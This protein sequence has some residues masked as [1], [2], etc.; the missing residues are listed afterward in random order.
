M[1]AHQHSDSVIDMA[2]IQSICGNDTDRI[3][4]YFSY[5]IAETSELLNEIETAINNN[6]SQ[7]SRD[8]FHSL[9]GSAG[10]S[11]ILQIPDLCIQAEEKSLQS[12]WDA[13]HKIYAAIEIIFKK[14]QVEVEENF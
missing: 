3:K 1:V 8:L 6:N 2:Q 4:K 12:D 7:L 14:L 11:G 5:V 13:V 10:M 9:K